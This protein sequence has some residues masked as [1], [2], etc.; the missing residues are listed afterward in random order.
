MDTVERELTGSACVAD[1][2]P[3][4][5]ALTILLVDDDP[6]CRMLVKDAI[7]GCRA[8]HRVYEVANAEEAWRFLQRQAPYLDAPRPGLIYLDVQ[9]PGLDGLALLKKIKSTPEL[10]QIT[11]VMMTG[12]DDE[13]Y[14]RMAAASGAN[15]YTLKPANAERFMRTVVDST[16]YWLTINQY[17]PQTK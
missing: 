17:P 6:D 7:S 3:I 8:E 16:N 15:S 12:E 14:I 13:K 10:Q 2:S 11:T 9:M 1:E 4:E 5:E